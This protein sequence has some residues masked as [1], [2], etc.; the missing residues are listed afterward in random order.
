M[1]IENDHGEEY[2]LFVYF[3]KCKQYGYMHEIKH[4]VDL[5]CKNSKWSGCMTYSK[6]TCSGMQE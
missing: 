2:Y 4:I 3:F 6:Q 1:E 5:I